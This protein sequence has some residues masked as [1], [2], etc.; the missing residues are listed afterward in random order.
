M[1]CCLSLHAPGDL[2]GVHTGRQIG[3]TCNGNGECFFIFP[4]HLAHLRARPLATGLAAIDSPGACWLLLKAILLHFTRLM[5][6]CTQPTFNICLYLY[7]RE[8]NGAVKAKSDVKLSPVNNYFTSMWLCFKR[9]LDTYFSVQKCDRG[10]RAEKQMKLWRTGIEERPFCFHASFFEIWWEGDE[11]SRLIFSDF[12]IT[13]T[14]G[15]ITS[16]VFRHGW[17]WRL[18]Y[19]SG[20]D[21]R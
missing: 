10:K 2:F 20:R 5:C 15:R 18:R 7:T 21:D 9:S 3:A 11:K 6:I 12:S 1:T 19:N 14:A 17:P 8:W 16:G 4:V 13:F